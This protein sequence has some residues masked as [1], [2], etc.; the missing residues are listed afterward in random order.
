MYV[1]LINFKE[2]LEVI[3]YKFKKT[4]HTS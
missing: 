1:Y 2:V 3:R 4:Y